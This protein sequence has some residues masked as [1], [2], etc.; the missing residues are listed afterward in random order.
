ME[1]HALVRPAEVGGR[2]GR[3]RLV[4]GDDR[5]RDRH[6]QQI[7]GEQPAKAT[8]AAAAGTP[9]QGLV[10]APR[11]P[12]QSHTEGDQR[13]AGEAGEHGGHVVSAQAVDGDV[14]EAVHRARGDGQRPADEGRDR[15][16]AGPQHRVA[17]R[18]RGGDRDR[19]EAAE[20][21]LRRGRTGLATKASSATLRAIRPIA[22]RKARTSRRPA[23]AP[24]EPAGERCGDA[25]VAVMAPVRRAVQGGRGSLGAP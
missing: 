18:Q 22:T 5:D 10:E 25:A 19:S 12:E 8:T 3:A 17:E 6:D 2:D 13:E 4:G 24:A 16:E 14:T 20:Q 9:R 1:R 21:V 7:G 15:A 11:P 23:A